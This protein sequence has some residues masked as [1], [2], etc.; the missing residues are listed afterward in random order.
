MSQP[1]NRGDSELR[2]E[3][4]FSWGGARGTHHEAYPAGTTMVLLDPDAATAFLTSASVGRPLDCAAIEQCQQRRA[5]RSARYRQ[6]GSAGAVGVR[7]G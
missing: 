3:Y 7:A 5:A 4:D 2:P 1:L 6:A